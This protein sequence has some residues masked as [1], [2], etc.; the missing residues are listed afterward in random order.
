MLLWHGEFA[1]KLSAMTA[2]I[3]AVRQAALEAQSRTFKQQG[4]EPRTSGATG[5]A[6][7][8][9]PGGSIAGAEGHGFAT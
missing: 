3:A 2:Y 1:C 5:R 9:Q 6:G 8:Q 7:R 4:S